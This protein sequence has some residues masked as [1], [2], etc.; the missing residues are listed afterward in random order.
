MEAFTDL[1]AAR[2]F[3]N[4]H[5]GPRHARR[6][7]Q[8]VSPVRSPRGSKLPEASTKWWIPRARPSRIRNVGDRQK[9]ERAEYIRNLKAAHR[10][11]SCDLKDMTARVTPKVEARL[12]QETLQAEDEW[13]RFSQKIR[14]TELEDAQEHRKQMASI[15]HGAEPRVVD[16]LSGNIQSFRTRCKEE[17][18]ESLM[19]EA[20][21]RWLREKSLE[22]LTFN[23]PPRVVDELSDATKDVRH[24][25]GEMRSRMREHDAKV[26]ALQGRS[27]EELRDSAAAK[28]D[29]WRSP[30]VGQIQDLMQKIGEEGR[31]TRSKAIRA[32]SQELKSLVDNKQAAVDCYADDEVKASSVSS[33]PKMLAIEAERRPKISPE[34]QEIDAD[35]SEQV[36]KLKELMEAVRPGCTERKVAPRS[37]EEARKGA[38]SV[39]RLQSAPWW[40][41]GN[42]SDRG[43][44]STGGL[45]QVPDSAASHVHRQSSAPFVSSSTSS[46]LA[47]SRSLVADNAPQAVSDYL[48]YLRAQAGLSS[49]ATPPAPTPRSFLGNS[50]LDDSVH[51]F[52]TQQQVWPNSLSKAVAGTSTPPTSVGSTHPESP[53]RSSQASATPRSPHSSL[54]AFSGHETPRTLLTP[55]NSALVAPASGVHTALLRTDV[56]GLGSATAPVASAWSDAQ[57]AVGCRSA[58]SGPAH[59]MV[60][61]LDMSGYPLQQVAYSAPSSLQ[62][63]KSPPV[64]LHQNRFI[65]LQPAAN[66][67]SPQFR[68]L[69]HQM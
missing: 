16:K 62:A 64:A 21:H 10:E 61:R 60:R 46:C 11:R 1:S 58:T 43:S 19:H 17:R 27:V 63:L 36:A 30:E 35:S 29:S 51:S 40:I 50:L 12:S 41:T 55:S 69:Q 24:R 39:Q 2:S 28:V 66:C 56:D 13:M 45:A 33:R 9:R 8:E 4:L 20:M 14:E 25:L 31:K 47:A 23:A 42:S 57:A 15:I 38:P 53:W 7:T 59:V 3:L 32:H 37:N 18:E 6:D 22:E 49:P 44:R 48:E 67:C 5:S 52:R 34:A 54:V 68:A 65:Q 26:F